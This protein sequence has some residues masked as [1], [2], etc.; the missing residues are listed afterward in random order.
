V[1]Q[2]PA[3]LTIQFGGQLRI[4]VKVKVKIQVQTHVPTQASTRLRTL[5]PALPG[6]LLRVLLE[7]G[8]SEVPGR[9]QAAQVGYVVQ[10]F[11]RGTGPSKTTFCSGYWAA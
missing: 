4:Q 9:N 10:T 7:E 1:E 8:Q 2:L 5:L 3:L 11:T 6:E